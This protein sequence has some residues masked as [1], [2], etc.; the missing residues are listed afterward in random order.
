MTKESYD[1]ATQ[2]VEKQRALEFLSLYITQVEIGRTQLI[3]ISDT[4]KN[5]WVPFMKAQLPDFEADIRKMYVERSRA[6]IAAEKE[7]LKEEFE[8]L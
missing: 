1:K 8:R 3:T 6:F 5:V 4:F 7:R 2:I